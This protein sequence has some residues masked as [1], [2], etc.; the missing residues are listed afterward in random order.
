M[1][2]NDLN[3]ENRIDLE[4]LKNAVI[5]I[6]A[7]LGKIIVGQE[8]FID[9]LI[10]A[11]LADGHVLIEGVPGVAKTITAKLLAKTIGKIAFCFTFKVATNDNG[12]LHKV[13]FSMH[14]QQT[15]FCF[16]QRAVKDAFSNQ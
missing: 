3:F 14:K 9:L 5:Q 4:K 1:E 6:K 12:F 15:S 16:V 11:L 8:N 7:E 2:N 10:V 13:P